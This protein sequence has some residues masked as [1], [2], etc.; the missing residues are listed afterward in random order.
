MKAV[1]CKEFGPPESLVVDDVPAPVP[2][3]S[4][5]RIGVHAAGV[6][7]PDTLIIQDKYQFKP[8]LPFSP[9]G[10]IAGEVLEVGSEVE[11]VAVGDCVAAMIGWGGF[12]EQ[13]VV[14]A[15]QVIPVPKGMDYAHAAGFG[16]VYGTSHYAL[17]QR[18]KLQP[19]ETLLVLGAAGGVG[20]AAVRTRQACRC[21]CDRR[22]RFRRKV[23]C[24]P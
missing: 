14:D 22:C 10:E 8:S 11:G 19:G 4:Q 18:A 3:T 1:V 21:P 6:N 13:V 20:L 16:M 15:S 23:R 9:G 5:V 7:F 2:T 24:L 17:K 12:A